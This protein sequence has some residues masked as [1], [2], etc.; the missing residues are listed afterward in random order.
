[1]SQGFTQGKLRLLAFT[2]CLLCRKP[3]FTMQLHSV[4]Q[5]SG[6]LDIRFGD[7]PFCFGQV[8]QYLKSTAEKQRL[9]GWAFRLSAQFLHP[10]FVKQVTQQQA[11]HDPPKTRT[12]RDPKY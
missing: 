7:P 11:N 9:P 12:R 5:L 6:Q 3:G 10:D 1:M 4:H 8:P 2:E